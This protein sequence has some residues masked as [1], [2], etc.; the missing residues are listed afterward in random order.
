V[1]GIAAR[2]N[3]NRVAAAELGAIGGTIGGG[4]ELLGRHAAAAVRGDPDGHGDPRFLGPLLHAR[5]DAI[6]DEE[7]PFELGFGEEHAELVPSKTGGEIVLPC[8]SDERVGDMPKRAIATDV[9]VRA[10]DVP[11]VVDVDHE[12]GDRPVEAVGAL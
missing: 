2:W 9:P 12:D 8:R 6:G 7:G 5:P 10:V 11:Q 1:H 3:G 4:D